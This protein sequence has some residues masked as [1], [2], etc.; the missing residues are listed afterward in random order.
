MLC[1]INLI[2][3]PKFKPRDEIGKEKKLAKEQLIQY[4]IL[5]FVFE[6]PKAAQGIWS[7]QHSLRLKGIALQAALKT[8]AT[9]HC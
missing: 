2:K 5:V 4:S 1:N 8:P 6:Y 3:F 7:L 9:V